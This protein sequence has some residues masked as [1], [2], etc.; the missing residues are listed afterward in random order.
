MVGV[1][2]HQHVR[3]TRLGRDPALDEAGGCGTLHDHVLARPA[4]IPRP[5][6]D[7]DPELGRHDVEAFGDILADDVEVA[8]ATGA[9]AVVEVDHP[10]D[11]RQV[12]RQGAAVGAT[13]AGAGRAG[14]CIGGVGLGEV[15]RLDLLGLLQAQEQLVDGQALGAP[16]EAVTLQLPD[17]LVQPVDLGLARRQHR[18]QGGGIV[19]QARARFAHKTDLSM[20]HKALPE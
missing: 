6:G 19:G 8:T 1:L 20:D 9:G 11:A 16:S 17:D 15:L 4:G 18:L 12:R 7:D 14:R 13:L 10:L 3:H 2:G 5:T